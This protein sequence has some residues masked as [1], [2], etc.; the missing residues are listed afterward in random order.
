MSVEKALVYD[1][2]HGIFKIR[3][4]LSLLTPIV[5]PVLWGYITN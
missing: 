5:L 2:T 3:G 4:F 1:T